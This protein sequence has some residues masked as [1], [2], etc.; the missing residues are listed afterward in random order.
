MKLK[1]ILIAIFS[2]FLF[3]ASIWAAGFSLR[4]DQPKSPS[5]IDHFSL[6]GVS[7]DRPNATRNITVKCFKKGPSDSDYSQFDVDQVLIPGGNVYSCEVT[8]TILNA[9]GVYS[10]YTTASVTEPAAEQL[11][12][13]VVT[14]DYNTSGPDTPVSYSKERLNDCDYKIKFKTANDGKTVK[15]QIFRSDNLNIHLDSGS[16][17]TSIS[18]GPNLEGETTNSIPVCGKTYYYVIR[19]VDASDNVSGTIGDSFTTTT[20]PTV[21]NT[22]SGTQGTTGTEAILLTGSSSQVTSPGADTEGEASGEGAIIDEQSGGTPSI[23][24]SSTDDGKNKLYQWFLVVLAILI[25]YSI[26]KSRKKGK[27]K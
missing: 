7:L 1:L 27:S 3:P 16:L 10:F 2:V 24:G 25:G 21:I 18:I 19:A 23:L 14:Y 26:L 22:T 4:V 5:K 8:N 20:N 13:N 17:I 6:T 11:T 12:S 15:V 9:N